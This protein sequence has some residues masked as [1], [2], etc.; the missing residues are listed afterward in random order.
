[1]KSSHAVPAMFAL[2]LLSSALPAA[3][4]FEGSV[5]LDLVKILVGN[6]RI[7]GEPLLY[8]D[9]MDDFPPLELPAE[10]TVIGSL[11]RGYNQTVALTTTL[12]EEAAST[13]LESVFVAA[14]WQEISQFNPGVQQESGFI[15]PNPTVEFLQYC[16]DQYGNMVVTT[17]VSG[18]VR[19]VSL[20]HTN[21]RALGNVQSSCEDQ[22]AQ[23]QGRFRPRQADIAQ[24]M[25]RLELPPR[26]ANDVSRGF[27]FFSGGSGG[28]GS[29]NDY[30]TRSQLA[31]DLDIAG[32]FAHF[33]AQVVAQGWAADAEA[34]GEAF[35]S[36][37]WTRTVEG[38]QEIIGVLSVVALGEEAYDLRFRVL[39]RATAGSPFNSPGIRG[40]AIRVDP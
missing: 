1:M 6:S 13:A 31:S 4:E 26:P 32:V 18:A 12:E 5:P 14:G 24:Y 23:M 35:A 9:I 3:T 19:Q 40:S 30:E 34:V 36:G 10:F 29:G 2:S 33:A 38:D 21:Q 17:T 11:D 15:N 8:A 22:I 37:S 25:P 16:H 28:S 39:G 27:G 20:S 7:M